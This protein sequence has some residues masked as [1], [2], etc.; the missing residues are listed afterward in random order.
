MTAKGHEVEFADFLSHQGS[1]NRILMN[2]P[3]EKGQDIE[4]VRHAYSLLA[5]GGR[6][7]SVMSEGPFFREDSK[8]QGF[9]AWLSEVDATTEQLPED[10][11]QGA[12]AFRETGVRTRLV[13]IDK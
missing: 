7:V 3:F 5:A 8:A 1:Y 13:V 10:A 9:R 6:L 12:D 11:F 2:P 4:H